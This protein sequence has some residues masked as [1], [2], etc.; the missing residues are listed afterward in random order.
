MLT[1]TNHL[2]KLILPEYG[3]NI[4]DMV[5]YCLTIENREE[6]QQCAQTIIDAMQIIV[7]PTGDTNEYHRKLWDHLW[8]MSGFNLDIDYPYEHADMSSFSEPPAPLPLQM[9]NDMQIRHYGV[10]IPRMIDRAVDMG[11][12]PEQ[13]A[14]IYLIANQMKK[15][16]LSN[17][18]ENVDDARIFNEIRNLS[19]GQIIIDP[20]TVR[21][22]DYR[23]APTPSGKKKKKK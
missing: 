19:H 22:N 21:L 5:D 20:E 9:P 11:P 7:P 1:Y 4:Q 18:H 15:T 23:Q 12:G 8:I 10:Y 2:R 14:I 3:R 6:R 16:L 17:Y 13:D